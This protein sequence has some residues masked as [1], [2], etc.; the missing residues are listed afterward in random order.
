M[1]TTVVARHQA[2]SLLDLLAYRVGQ[3]LLEWAER[4]KAPG[5]DVERL[6]EAEGRR[7]DARFAEPLGLHHWIR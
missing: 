5:I 7:A 4:P 6:A 1:S 3:A 2:P